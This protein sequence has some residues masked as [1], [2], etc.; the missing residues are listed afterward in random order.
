MSKELGVALASIYSE[1]L[2]QR[3]PE[4]QPSY[5]CTAKQTYK[6]HE[7]KKIHKGRKKNKLASIARKKTKK[8]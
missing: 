7:L 4:Q 3:L 6:P 5:G 1:Y 2:F 8:V